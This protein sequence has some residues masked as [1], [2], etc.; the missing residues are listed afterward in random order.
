MT[1]SRPAR[2]ILW[3]SAFAF[4]LLTTAHHARAA[5]LLQVKGANA[6]IEFT[7][8]ETLPSEGSQFYGFVGG[9]K[10][11]VIEITKV[12][13]HRAV[14]RVI[15]GTLDVDA[16]LSP[17]ASA[18]NKPAPREKKRPTPAPPPKGKKKSR[19]HREA[20]PFEQMTFGALAGY[21]LDTQ[22]VTVSGQSLTMTGAGM[23]LSAFVDNPISGPLGL[24]TRGGVEQFSVKGS[25]SGA[26]VKT[27]LLYFTLDLLLRY[28]FMEGVFV[29]QAFGG[30]SIHVPV[31]KSSDVL[32]TNQIST[33]T[34]FPIGIGAKYALSG[35]WYLTGSTE[36]VYFMPSSQVT[37][38]AIAVRAGGG[39][40]F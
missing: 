38:S 29:P 19:Y 11:A 1:N 32:D 23:S 4:T 33:T 37:T 10:K 8:E 40:S 31:A 22:A 16:T 3:R 25:K 20:T 15:S 7:N 30:I 27:D 17:A 12:K 28:D 26:N 39:L 24:I 36:Y 13:G 18:A 21:A 34:V 9:E 2:A 35:T 14:G 6:L 5:Q